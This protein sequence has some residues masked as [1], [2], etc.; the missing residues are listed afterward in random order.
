MVPPA[1]N[2]DQQIDDLLWH[3]LDTVCG[4][5]YHP[6]PIFHPV[7]Y[8]PLTVS[9]LL[10]QPNLGGEVRI[11]HQQLVNLLNPVP[12]P[13]LRQFDILDELLMG[14]CWAVDVGLSVLVQLQHIQEGFHHL[15]PVPLCIQQG[16]YF[17]EGDF[18]F[19]HYHIDSKLD[20]FEWLPDEVLG[21][22][23]DSLPLQ[24]HFEEGLTP[25]YLLAF[26]VDVCHQDE[27]FPGYDGIG[28]VFDFLCSFRCLIVSEVDDILYS[29]VILRLFLVGDNL[30]V[31]AWGEYNEV[32]FGLV[33]DW[34]FDE[35]GVGVGC[36]IEPEGCLLLAL[37]L[38][39]SPH[40]GY[41]VAV[42]GGGV[43]FV[44]HVVLPEFLAGGG[45]AIQILS[46]VYIYIQD[47]QG[48]LT[49]GDA[50]SG[51]NSGHL[52][53]L[54]TVLEEHCHIHRCDQPT[55]PIVW[56]TLPSNH[57]PM[58]SH[59]TQLKLQQCRLPTLQEEYLT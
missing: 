24:V 46:Q 28:Q 51:V 43:I 19:Q 58:V 1:C 4:H 18:I 39:E 21:D 52:Q 20:D 14:A 26:Q 30:P 13:L 49:A 11:H 53:F 48:F 17:L 15:Y 50:G 35:G 6:L 2:V 38:N 9:E 34:V 16:E 44:L 47:F 42:V 27:L 45:V 59:H 10:H 12:I 36:L 22:V 25:R 3:C 56:N 37:W 33:V 23:D 55:V 32:V 31:W 8:V 7:E 40:G 5:H 54:N 57:M 29:V 41:E